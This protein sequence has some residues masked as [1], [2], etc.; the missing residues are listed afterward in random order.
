MATT[1]PSKKA[2]PVLWTTFALA[3]ALTTGQPEMAVPL[4]P[5]LASGAEAQNGG[6]QKEITGSGIGS[7][8]CGGG[9][10]P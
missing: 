1:A 6:W 10:L 2:T 7:Q 9:E 4:F 3:L 5:V 8:F